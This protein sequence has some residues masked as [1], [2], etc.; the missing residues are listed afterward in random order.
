ME[1]VLQAPGHDADDAWM[2]ALT[3]RNQHAA[4]RVRL[5]RAFGLRSGGIKDGGFKSLAFI[6]QGVEAFGEVDGFCPV[7]RGKELGGEPRIADAAAGIEA[8]AKDESGVVDGF[9]PADAGHIREGA[10]AGVLVAGHHGQALTHEGAIDA[11]QGRHVA[12]GAERAEVQQR[13]DVGQPGGWCDARAR[14]RRFMAAT[15]T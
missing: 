7:V 5:E 10:Q 1:P 4:I 12:Q 14:A 11:G 13:Q 9:D 15:K 6:I 3:G 2:P 8:R